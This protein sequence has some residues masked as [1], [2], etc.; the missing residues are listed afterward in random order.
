M[1]STHTHSCTH[2]HTHPVLSTYSCTFTLHIYTFTLTNT[3]AHLHSHSH[4]FTHS[5]TCSHSCEHHPHNTPGAKKTLYKWSPER[6]GTGQNNHSSP[7][8]PG[9]RSHLWVQEPHNSV[10][11]PRILAHLLPKHTGWER[12]RTCARALLT[13]PLQ[14]LTHSHPMSLMKT[15]R[16]QEAE[17]FPRTHMH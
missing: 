13:P 6:S 10:C 14:S 9:A 17:H 12:L 2:V 5:H 8:Q 4:S 11:D 1:H 3:N 15:P 16:V 7:A